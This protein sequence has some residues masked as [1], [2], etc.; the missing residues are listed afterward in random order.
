[1]NIVL[2]GKAV[3]DLCET[4]TF[5]KLLNARKEFT[6]FGACAGGCLMVANALLQAGVT[7]VLYSLW[8][9]RRPP[10][11]VVR[12]EMIAQYTPHWQHALPKVGPN[13]YLDGDGLKTELQVYDWW[14]EAFCCT[15]L[16]PTTKHWRRIVLCND[17][18]GKEVPYHD[19]V[20]DNLA[21]YFKVGLYKRGLLH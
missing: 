5:Y 2:L 19:D 16:R 14:K 21:M 8:G 20:V 6:P 13:S 9:K 1:M 3:Q 11:W 15:A 7:G 18:M 4:R 12:P 10:L 17:R